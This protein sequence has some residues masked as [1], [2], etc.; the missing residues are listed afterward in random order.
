[1][2]A[3]PPHLSMFFCKF[4]RSYKSALKVPGEWVGREM[5]IIIIP[6]HSVKSSWITLN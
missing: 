6:L 3:P 4:F 1:M 5:T 2:L